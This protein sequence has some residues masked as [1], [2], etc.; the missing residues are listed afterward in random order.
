MISYFRRFVSILFAVLALLTAQNAFAG[1]PTSS[2]GS[3]YCF[4]G[5]SPT[6]STSSTLVFDFN[7]DNDNG[8]APVAIN[9]FP[10]PE[11]ENNGDLCWSG[12]VKATIYNHISA[13]YPA[14]GTATFDLLSS[15]G[16][17]KGICFSNVTRSIK[18]DSAGTMSNGC[19][20]QTYVYSL[21]LNDAAL[22]S[23]GSY[24]NTQLAALL[25]GQFKVDDTFATDGAFDECDV[26][27]NAKICKLQVGFGVTNDPASFIGFESLFPSEATLSG[28]STDNGQVYYSDEVLV[29]CDPTA[30]GVTNPDSDAVAAKSSKIYLSES[31]SMNAHWCTD[32]YSS[33]PDCNA[34]N[35]DDPTQ[36]ATGQIKTAIGDYQTQN[37]DA[38][39]IDTMDDLRNLSSC[40]TEIALATCASSPDGFMT[41]PDAYVGDTCQDANLTAYDVETFFFTPAQGGGSSTVNVV[42]I[43]ANADAPGYSGDN[44][45][46]PILPGWTAIVSTPDNQPNNWDL[47]GIEP[48]NVAYIHVRNNDD[49]VVGTL[50]GDN[51]LGGSG[52]DVLNGNDGNDILQGGDNADTLN[53]DGGND[54]ILGYECNSVNATC[55]TFLNNGSDNDV[56]NGG[57]GDDC[58][59]GGRGN[60]SY[61][62]GSGNDAFVLFGNADSDT[63]TD[64]TAGED[65]IVD[66]IGNATAKWV[67]GSNKDNTPSVCEVVTGGNNAMIIEGISSLNS[68]NSVTI[69]HVTNGDTLPAQCTGHPFSYLP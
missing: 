51:I 47:S 42:A 8:L 4:F 41:F 29:A 69:L 12:K 64:Y 62:G 36:R 13:S 44:T 28:E 1:F 33:M 11:N 52:V 2:G 54:L 57:A 15:A 55:G 3:S 7:P 22:T 34:F 16:Q 39:C 67:K 6:T 49:L 27:P 59:D 66:M 38:T 53:G 48:V 17:N 63:V 23:S 9:F 21:V 24:D 46:P 50:K 35:P 56:L 10:Y 32:A 68:C 25:N 37:A 65:V 40:S 30:V 45:L 61:T 5:C 60:D 18:P 20:Y 14:T 43:G 19:T 26:N 31:L 58:L